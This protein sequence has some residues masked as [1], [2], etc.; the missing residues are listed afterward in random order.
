[1][2]RFIK[3]V[4]LFPLSI[5][6]GNMGSTARMLKEAEDAENALFGDGEVKS[7][8]DPKPATEG[9]AEDATPEPEKVAVSPT[10]PAVAELQAELASQKAEVA[11]LVRQLDD[12][13]SPTFRQKYATLQ[14]MFNTETAKLRAELEELKKAVIEKPKEPA[15]AA[16]TEDYDTLV[17]EVGEKTA[18]IL[19]PYLEKIAALES[20]VSGVAGEVKNVAGEVKTTREKAGQLEVAQAQTAEER[21]F[22]NLNAISPNWKKINGWSEEGLSQDPRFSGFM[23]QVIPGTSSTYQDVLNSHY[24]NRNAVKVAEIFDLFKKSVVIGETP[25]QDDPPKKQSAA[26][27]MEKYIEPDKTG[28]GA[29]IPTGQEDIIPH[30][31]Y[32]TFVNAVTRGTFRG[33]RDERAKL[34][35][36]YDKALAENRIR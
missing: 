31:E 22:A 21:F 12:E 20:T 16:N 29:T 24:S 13:N 17:A 34:E 23:G 3:S 10:V 36:R 26:A 11:R 5:I 28:K 8:E 32:D 6:M 35:A 30:A 15:V 7:T 33:T 2:K 19:K 14:G 25:K 4:L 9:L 1:M 18:K 27:E